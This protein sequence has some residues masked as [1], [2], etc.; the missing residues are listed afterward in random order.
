M[1]IVIEECG[2]SENI[3]IVKD[4]HTD[5]SDILIIE[6]NEIQNSDTES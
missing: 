4:G 5:T 1:H 6:Y 3:K 2:G